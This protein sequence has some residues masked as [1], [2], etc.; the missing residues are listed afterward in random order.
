MPALRGFHDWIFASAFFENGL[1]KEETALYNL[2][3]KLTKRG[4]DC[5][6][7][8]GD[9]EISTRNLIWIMPT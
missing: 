6:R 7:L 3:T 1:E 4:A 5:C 9:S 2:R 8:R